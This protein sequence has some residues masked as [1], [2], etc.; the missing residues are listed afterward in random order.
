MAAEEMRSRHALDPHAC[1][2]IKYGEVTE[3]LHGMKGA[4]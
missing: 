2:T 1:V 4:L 3:H